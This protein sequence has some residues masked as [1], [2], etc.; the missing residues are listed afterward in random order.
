MS[1]IISG[2]LLLCCLL[3]FSYIIFLRKQFK[4]LLLILKDVKNGE[5][6]KIFTKAKGVVAEAHFEV[7]DLITKYQTEIVEQKKIE[8]ANKQLLTSLSH[9]VRTPLT[10]LLGYLDALESGIVEGKEKE[11]YIHIARKKAY[12]LK[13]LI[14]TLLDWFKIDSKEMQFFIQEIDMN[15][16]L[17]EVIIDWLPV[18]EKNN[19]QLNSNIPE[20]ELILKIDKSSFTRII[21]NLMQN[22]L[23]H[24]KCT[25]ISITVQKE[26]DTVKL[27]IEDNGIGISEEKMPFI[28]DRLYKGDDSRGSKGSGLGLCIVRELVKMHR[29]SISVKSNRGENTVFMIVLPI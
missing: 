5:K 23:R 24:S 14:D 22:A 17:R 12:D 10:S 25:K 2:I 7:N 1:M 9:D 3:L 27:S 19:I 13:K 28:F 21:S 15:E 4:Q 11:R 8:Q 20:E 16:L 6:K 26:M 18:L 29:G